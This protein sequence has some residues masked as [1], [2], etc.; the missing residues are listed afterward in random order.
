MPAAREDETSS[1]REASEGFISGVAVQVL[2][3]ITGILAARIL[4]EEGRGQQALIWIIALT[5]AQV[6]MFGL[7]LAITYESAKGTASVSRLLSHIRP[8]ATLQGAVIV[9]VYATVTLLFLRDRLPWEAAA[10][11]ILA[12]PAMVW[13]AYGLALIQG[14]HEFRALHVLRITPA[15]LYVVSLTTGVVLGASSLMLVMSC[16]SISYVVAAVAT[17]AYV[18]RID[19]R[20]L[21]SELDEL[22]EVG[23]LARFGASGFLGSASPTETFKV[24]QLIVGLLLSTGDLALYVTALAFCNFPRLLVQAQGLVAYARIAAESDPAARRHLMVRHTMG[25]TAIAAAVSAVLALLAG[26]LIDLTF[27]PEFSGATTITQILLGGTVI[28]CARR[29]LSEC[30]RG[31]G[32]PGAGSVAEIVSLTALIPALVV[33]VPPYGLEG[34][35]LGM[36]VSYLAGLLVLLR[37]ASRAQHE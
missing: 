5:V 28:L 22:P 12:L 33:F 10:I 13:Q 14:R 21:G 20:S 25:A 18:R 29:M 34:F 2:V 16:W 36:I 17:A 15:A 7:P 19:G 4:G 24:D 3:L 27:G 32:A 30:M 26:P 23:K 11:T 8:L 6:G 37:S 31:M 35:A 1:R 9:L